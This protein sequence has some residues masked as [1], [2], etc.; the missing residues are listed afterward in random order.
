MTSNCVGHRSSGVN[1]VRSMLLF[2]HKFH[3]DRTLT[4]YKARLVANASSS[5]LLQLIIDSLHSEFDMTDL[6]A[7]N[8]FLGI[9]VVRHPAGLFLSQRKYAL[10]LLEHVHMVN[11]NP[12][13]TPIDTKS[14]P[15]PQASSSALL[16]LIIDS[17]HSEFDMTDL[18]A[19]NYFLG[20]SVVR[21]PAGLFLSQRKYALKL[22]EHVHMVN[23]NPSQT[24]ID[25]KSKP[26]PQVTITLQ[27]KVVD[28]SLGI[29]KW[30]QSLLRSY[31]EKKNNTQT[32]FAL[33]A[34]SS[35]SSDNEVYDDSYC[36]K[37]C[38][39]NTKNLNTKINKLNEELS[40]CEI[41]LY[42]YKRGLSQVEARLV[43]FK[44]NEVKLCERIRVLKRDVEIRDNKIEYL[45]NE[46]EQVKK[47]KESLD[48]KLT[49]FENALKDLD[50][51]LGSQIS[52]KN[53]EGLGYS[54]VPPFLHKSIY[55]L[56]KICLG[57]VCL[58]LLMILLLTIVGLHLV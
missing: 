12:S 4:C 8:Y 22:L 58:S 3:A 18:E 40:D 1:M 15:G 35:S 21:H 24:P 26:G 7:L 57:H 51:L 42:N 9:S 38:W 36:F 37:S 55:L 49:G 44:E 31:D 53:K 29:N 23:C 14:K 50:N 34:K 5:A 2:K 52:D 17:L 6:E 48:D 33:M 41:D 16:Q 32:E 13:Q 10:K 27:A 39:K 46:L 28:P 20:I 19:L 25:T 47:E 56:R 43:K 30:Y 11:C 54:A 45:K